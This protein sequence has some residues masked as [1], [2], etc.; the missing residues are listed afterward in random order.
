MI[1]IDSAD[2]KEIDW[3]F[4]LGIAAGVTTNPILLS[5]VMTA[6]ETRASWIRQILTLSSGPVS[7]QLVKETEDEMVHEA[8]ILRDLDSRI[9]IKV[10]F[11]EVGLR[12]TKRLAVAQGSQAPFNSNVTAIMSAHQAALALQA[13][14]RY[15]SLFAGRMKDA[16][17][18]V[19]IGK[20][21]MGGR[22][23]LVGHLKAT[24]LLI[25]RYPETEIIV[26]SLRMRADAVNAIVYGAHIV[27]VPPKLLRE[28][29]VEPATE[30]VL[31]EFRVAAKAP[32][33][34][35]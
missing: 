4:S 34:P 15:V 21:T 11:S 23:Y 9:V 33:I 20:K 3:A 8:R 19:S 22:D 30:K 16:N 27:T 14:A 2:L 6:H 24:R 1:F 7:V 10:P 26:G 18:I 35:G 28:M 13:G 12:V 5:R 25:N 31:E 17:D 29:L 32:P